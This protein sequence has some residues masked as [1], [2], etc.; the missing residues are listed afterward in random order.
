MDCLDAVGARE[1][2]FEFWDGV[3]GGNF[4][5]LRLQVEKS[6]DVQA[7]ERF[8]GL[9]LALAAFGFGW[10]WKNLLVCTRGFNREYVTFLHICCGD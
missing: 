8:F 7:G 9:T 5:P 10:D 1:Q 2:L 4:G 6:I 3:L